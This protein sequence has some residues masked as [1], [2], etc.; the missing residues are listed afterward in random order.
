M[1]LL[2]I[3]DIGQLVRAG[4]SEK[5]LIEIERVMGAFIDYRSES[6]IRSREFL[7]QVREERKNKRAVT[8]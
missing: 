4:I 8:G 7:M 5:L 3:T 2:L 1:R 6:R